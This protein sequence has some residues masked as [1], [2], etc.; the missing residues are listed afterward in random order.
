MLWNQNVSDLTLN[1]WES[2]ATGKMYEQS[3]MLAHKINGRD[4]KTC[5]K[6]KKFWQREE[7]FQVLCKSQ[8]FGQAARSRGREKDHLRT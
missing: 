5:R 3:T 7:P 1:I 4:K 2:Y 6:L 8:P